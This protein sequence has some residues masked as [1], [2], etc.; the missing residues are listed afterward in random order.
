MK[1]IIVVG[2][3]GRLGRVVVNGLKDYEVIRAG[4]SG[5]DLKID[6]LDFESVSDVFA[7]V[8]IFDGLISCIG[9][10]PFKTFEE[11]TMEDFALG[12]SKKCFSQLNL[13]KAAIP[14]L[15]DNGSITLTSGIIGDEPILAGSCAAAANGAL[16]MSVSTLAAEYAGRLRI[17]VVSPSIIEN[18]V[19]D[20]GMLF[21]GF[22]PT[23]EKRII[24]AYRRTISAPISGRVLRQ[25]RSL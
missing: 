1:K 12:M 24:E 23:S 20:Y 14:F 3:T 6:A 19:E 2:A 25:T 21:D 17:N 11:L 16:N 5:P 4:R 18:S 13:A 15:S 9:G 22:E 10:T 7:S 8:G